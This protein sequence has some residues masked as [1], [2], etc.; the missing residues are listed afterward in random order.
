MDN[1]AGRGAGK[2]IDLTWT[3]SFP[4]DE[5]SINPG[6]VH[7]SHHEDASGAL[8][9]VPGPSSSATVVDDVD[10]I[11]PSLNGQSTSVRLDAPEDGWTVEPKPFV[12]R[13][14][15]LY[16]AIGYQKRGGSSSQV[17]IRDVSF[18]AADFAKLKPGQVLIQRGE[19]V[20]LKTPETNGV[21]SEIVFVDKVIS[22]E[23][24][25]REGQNWANCE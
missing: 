9:S 21:N 23:D 15:V 1:D 3:P 25:E 22:Q 8:D 5:V 17:N 14:G 6:A 7:I 11:A 24:F 20:P 4:T 12:L 16:S 2:W 18:R 10:F 19:S 13:P